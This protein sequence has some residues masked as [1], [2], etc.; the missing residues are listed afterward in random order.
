MVQR[1]R[2]AQNARCVDRSFVASKVEGKSPVDVLN[3]SDLVFRPRL[4]Q[5]PVNVISVAGFNNDGRWQDEAS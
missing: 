1:P 4:G 3:V 2:Q 5:E